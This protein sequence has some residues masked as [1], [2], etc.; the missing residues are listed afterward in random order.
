MMIEFNGPSGAGKSH[1]KQ[2]LIELLEEKGILINDISQKSIQFRLVYIIKHPLLFFYQ[3]KYT[4]RLSGFSFRRSFL[5]MKT[6]LSVNSRYHR[7]KKKKK[8]NITDEGIVQ[9]SR[10]I[11]RLSK[12]ENW[13]R[14]QFIPFFVSYLPDIVVNVDADAESL[15]VRKRNRDKNRKY[16]IQ[17]AEKNIQQFK[18]TVSTLEEIAREKGS[19]KIFYFSNNCS[20][21]T[22]DD[23][24]KNLAQSVVEFY[25]K[26]NRHVF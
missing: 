11:L 13:T 9:K 19:I 7:L 16:K 20:K 26:E 6:F 1:L 22:Y 17:N 12:F 8:L 25:L 21:K 5:I 15:A 4:F 2:D 18:F 3:I 10:R 24:V 23:K 14:V